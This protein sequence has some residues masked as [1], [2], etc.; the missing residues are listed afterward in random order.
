MSDLVIALSSLD[1]DSLIKMAKIHCAN[2][3]SSVIINKKPLKDK[4]AELESF[5]NMEMV[6]ALPEDS[7]NEMLNM[8]D[9]AQE[10]CKEMSKIRK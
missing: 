7:K 1:K 5:K 4:I 8:F 10:S 9:N 6:E 2:K 3:V